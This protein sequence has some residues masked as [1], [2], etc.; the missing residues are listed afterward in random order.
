M[1]SLICLVLIILF[2]SLAV[3]AQYSPDELNVDL[4]TGDL[5]FCSPTSS[6]LSKAIDQTTQTGQDTHYD[7]VGIVDIKNDSVY[8][9]HAAPKKGVSRE[10]LAQFFYSYT[11]KVTI[12]IYRLNEKYVKSIPSAI[13]KAYTLLGKP[14]N[15]SYILKDPGIYCSEY[16]YNIFAP[17]SIF[18]LKA[19]TF[20]NP[21][22]GQFLIGWVNHYKKLG[23]AIPEGEPGCNPNAM[24]ASEK[25]EMTG[26]VIIDNRGLKSRK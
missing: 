2:A 25:L 16:I 26:E 23:I 11:E 21:K 20:K 12:T 4:Q 22:T 1:K 17:D 5:L 9:L 8:V 3:K 19:M 15:Q 10:T 6:E 14:Y 24:A 7:H 13:K 18:Q